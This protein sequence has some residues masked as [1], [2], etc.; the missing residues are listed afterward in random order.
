[1]FIVCSR[2]TVDKWD[3]TIQKCFCKAKDIIDRATQGS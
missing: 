3:L 1:M 2:L